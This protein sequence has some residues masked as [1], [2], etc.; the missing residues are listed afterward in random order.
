MTSGQIADHAKRFCASLAFALR[1]FVRGHDPL[2]WSC[3]AVADVL[4]QKIEGGA[5]EA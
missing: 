5:S 2:G 4:R 3:W 1:A